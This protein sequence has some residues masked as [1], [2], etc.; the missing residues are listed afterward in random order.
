MDAGFFTLDASC[1]VRD[2]LRVTNKV[3]TTFGA[4]PAKPP[5]PAAS[6]ESVEQLR[7]DMNERLEKL[8]KTVGDVKAVRQAPAAPRVPQAPPESATTLSLRASVLTLQRLTG[9]KRPAPDAGR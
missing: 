8:E 7:K 3:R 1:V 5:K 9:V 4:A 2:M 6:P